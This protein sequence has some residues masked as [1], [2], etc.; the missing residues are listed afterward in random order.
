MPNEY[1]R[2]FKENMEEV[3]LSTSR[4][5]F[6]FEVLQTRELTG[7]L[8]HTLEREPDFI[9]VVETRAGEEFIFHLE[10][11]SR[12][13]LNMLRRMRLYHAL[14]DEKYR[15]PIRQVVLYVGQAKPQMRTRFEPEEVMSGFV[16]LD[17][18]RLDVGQLS[19]HLAHISLLWI[20]GCFGW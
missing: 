10:F 18:H 1:D 8:Q 17:L 3:V 6:G 7:K 9:R 5:L 15:L 13:D 4:I 14:L 20:L 11:Q 2:I 19:W 16:L 12:D